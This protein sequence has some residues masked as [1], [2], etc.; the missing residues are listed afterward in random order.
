LALR[1][2]FFKRYYAHYLAVGH[3]RISRS[4]RIK[5]Q[6][7]MSTSEGLLKQ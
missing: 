3:Q 6:R 5:A 4:K 1:P 7:H 2:E